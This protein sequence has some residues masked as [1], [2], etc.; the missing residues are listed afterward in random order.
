MDRFGFDIGPVVSVTVL[1]R[2]Q[3][4]VDLEGFHPN[5]V[6]HNF[7]P[8]LVDDVLEEEL[9][10]GVDFPELVEDSDALPEDAGGSEFL[11]HGFVPL[12]GFVREDG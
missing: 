8:V 11:S 3:A 2:V 7:L 12:V 1:S 5:G 9:D 6:G 4:A 10:L